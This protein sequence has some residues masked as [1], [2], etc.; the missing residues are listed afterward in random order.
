MKVLRGIGTAIVLIVL[1][2]ALALALVAGPVRFM[3]LNPAYLKAFMPTRSYC[4]EMRERVSEDLDYVALLYGLDEGALNE[5]VTDESIRSFTNDMIDALF[6][7]ETKTELNLP[8]YPSEGFAAYL[9]E[10][11]SYSETAIRDFSEDCAA[12][13]TEDLSAIDSSLLVGAFTSFRDGA[14][15]NA[16]ILLFA[17]GAALT[18][19]MCA[20]LKL[21]YMGKSK[22][23][24][25]VV[26]WGGCFMGVT[27]VFVPVMQF[28]LFDYIGRLNVSISAFRTI[29]TGLLNTVLY[30]WF[31]VLLVL[32]LFTILML[33]LAIVRACRKKR[34]RKAEKKA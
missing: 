31:L 4:D 1:C 30:G 10:R 3:A 22:R 24:G 27:L 33:T 11:T 7:A 34:P 14:F 23:T 9:R 8:A 16:S 6:A 21:M 32:L 29:L 18:L 5:V 13:V 17:G 12:A 19:L 28:L 15:A 25:S 2:G 20:L 26:L